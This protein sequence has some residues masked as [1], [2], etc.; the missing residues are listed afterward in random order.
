M[1]KRMKKTNVLMVVVVG[2]M[3]IQCGCGGGVTRTGFLTDY[4]RLQKESGS[5]LRY[6][7]TRALARYSNFIVNRVEVHLH[8][9]AKS[10]GKLTQREINDLTNYMHA[11]IVK[12]VEDSGGAYR[13]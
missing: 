7:N 5:T 1:K 10:K 4:S 9:G 11:R 8:S 3:S 12:A 2:L 6:V 13:Y